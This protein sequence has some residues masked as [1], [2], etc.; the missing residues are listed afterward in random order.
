[1]EEFPK[2]FSPIPPSAYG[3]KAALRTPAHV[4]ESRN[5]PEPFSNMVRLQCTIPPG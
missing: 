3:L 1:M 4:R 5:A 2:G